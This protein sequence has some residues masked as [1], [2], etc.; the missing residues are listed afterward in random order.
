MG[1]R[2]SENSKGRTSSRDHV[3]KDGMGSY[4]IHTIRGLIARVPGG[5]ANAQLVDEAGRPMVL[6]PNAVI[7][8]V[9]VQGALQSNAG[10]TATISVGKS[11]SVAFYLPALDVKGT[12]GVGFPNLSGA[13]SPANLFGNQGSAAVPIFGQYLETGAAST[14]GGPWAVEIDYHY[15]V[16]QS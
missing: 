8:S 9:T 12:T 5:G 4:V 11:G 13:A 7:D 14:T 15:S 2:S 3:F 10:T 16:P 1:G 6:P